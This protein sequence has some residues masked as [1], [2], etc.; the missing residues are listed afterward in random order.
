MDFVNV[1]Y[2]LEHLQENPKNE[3]S[4]YDPGSKSKNVGSIFLSSFKNLS[5][6]RTRLSVYF[7]KKKNRKF[8]QAQTMAKEHY[9][10]PNKVLTI[11][12]LTKKR[13]QLQPKES[14]RP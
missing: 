13:N 1:F 5:F 6:L 4:T 7:I 12:F 2:V 10:L 9:P 3:P 8:I 11:T 14:P